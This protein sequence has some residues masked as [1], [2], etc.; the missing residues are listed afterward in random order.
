MWN[1]GVG[2]YYC[3]DQTLLLQGYFTFVM[4]V[5]DEIMVLL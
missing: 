5:S 1:K 2:L 4:E 3:L